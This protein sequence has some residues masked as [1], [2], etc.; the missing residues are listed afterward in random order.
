VTVLGARR[1]SQYPPVSATVVK[2]AREFPAVPALALFRAI[3]KARRAVDQG[4]PLHPDCAL[5]EIEQLARDELRG[6][7][8]AHPLGAEMQFPTRKGWRY[9]D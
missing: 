9:G 7:R 8:P 4:G 5:D 2:L 6:W 1:R 3:G